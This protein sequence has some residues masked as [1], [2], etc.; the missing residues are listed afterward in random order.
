M[1]I[2]ALQAAKQLCKQSGWRYTHLELQ[3]LIY[4]AHVI[5]YGSTNEPLVYGDYEA[6]SLGVVHPELYK[7]LRE[8]GADCIE[9]T[10]R[11]FKKTD[12]VVEGSDEYHCIE[13]VRSAFPPGNGPKLIAF[14]H[15]DGRAWEKIYQPYQNRAIPRELILEEF[16]SYEWEAP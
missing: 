10:F 13:V 5:H 1:T 14:N 15:Q 11:L 2:S 8:W 12:D 3:K 4:I 6:W 7:Q 9:E 16:N